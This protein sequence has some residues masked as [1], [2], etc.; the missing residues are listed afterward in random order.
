MSTVGGGDI[1]E[2]SDNNDFE[3]R[4]SAL[5]AAGAGGLNTTSG[6]GTTTSASYVDVPSSSVT[7]ITKVSS[8]THLFVFLR[9]TFYSTST[10]T[11][12]LFGVG[13]GGTDYD[14]GYMFQDTAF[15]RL[16][17]SGIR[18]IS[19][20]AAGAVTVQ[21]RWKRPSGAGTLTMLTSDHINITAVEIP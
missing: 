19:G 8:S 17:V 1:I 15:L 16:P 13:I 14:M 21:G 9:A 18:I 7:S 10:S 6:G 20:I 11:A 4:V 5:E 3:T 12:A 2:A